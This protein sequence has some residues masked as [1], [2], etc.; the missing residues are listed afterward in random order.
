MPTENE[1]PAGLDFGN[2]VGEPT[3][4][5]AV[6]EV[7]EDESVETDLPAAGDAADADT[8]SSDD[9]DSGTD[10]S[11]AGDAD[12]SVDG[13]AVEPEPAPVAEKGKKHLV[14]KERL[15]QSLRAR[16]AAE[17]RAEDLT[18]EL[19]LVRQEQAA[20]SAP[21]PMEIGE[22]QSKMAAANEALLAGDSA[23]AAELQAEVMSALIAKPVAPA[24]AEQRDV[25]AEVEQRIEF[26]QTLTAVY[27]EFPEMDPDSEDYNE[28]L[29]TESV[30]L[31]RGYMNRGFSLAE[32]TRKAGDAIA[33]LYDLENRVAPKA[34][35]VPKAD[36]A[37]R[38]LQNKTRA[39]IANAVKAPPQLNG[40]G[41]PAGDVAFD[42]NTAT[43][44]EFF[45]LPES[46]RNKLLGNEL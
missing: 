15:D 31:Q 5:P 25:A 7:I 6:A 1:L 43:E 38:E 37:K 32:A 24:P 46:V 14:P 20:A 45:A 9:G 28:E 4:T 11:E 40:T 19:A 29:A 33:K 42:I 13:P 12:E 34:A 8:D 16:R 27:K 26:K 44:E 36:P 22:I 18:A 21:K 30:D 35:P 41:E 3:S 39:K 23:K 2:E 17:Q 10:E